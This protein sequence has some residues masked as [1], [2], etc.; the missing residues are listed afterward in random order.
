[1]LHV[2]GEITS[3]TTSLLRRLKLQ[4]K[5]RSSAAFGVA[6]KLLCVSTCHLTHTSDIL[7]PDQE[8]TSLKYTQ[9]N[10]LYQSPRK[11]KTRLSCYMTQGLLHFVGLLAGS[12]GYLQS[13]MSFNRLPSSWPFILSF[14]ES[15]LCLRFSI[16]TFLIFRSFVTYY[17]LPYF[18]LPTLSFI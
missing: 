2:K 1:M 16:I 4:D 17:L 18:Y 9:M 6:R 10:S 5:G 12:F 11:Y 8:S 15:F 7:V 3:V 13:R 14:K